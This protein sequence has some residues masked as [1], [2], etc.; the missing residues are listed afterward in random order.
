MDNHNM[1]VPPGT[2]HG[3]LKFYVIGFLVSLIL[4][5]LSYIAVVYQLFSGWMLV[6]LI[7]LSAISQA[8][9]QLFLFLH[10]GS[11]SKPRWNLMVF[12]FMALVLAIIVLGSLWIMYNLDYRM[13]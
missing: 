9:V 12:L 8:L 6:G 3:S 5:L 10:L 2:D 11:E 13:M 4:T 1:G 7:S